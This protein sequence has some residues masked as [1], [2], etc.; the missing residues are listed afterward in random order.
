LG[1][2][3]TRQQFNVSLPLDLVRR[4]KH[5]A[6][7]VQ[8]SLSDLVAHALHAELAHRE[9]SVTRPS[10]QDPPVKLQ[11]MVHVE[12]MAAAVSFYETLGATVIHGSRDGDWALLSLGESQLALLA[13]PPNP[14]Q[15]EGTVE[16]NF[17]ATQPLDQLEDRLRAAGVTI[18][19][20]TTD[21][22]FGRQLQLASPDGL[23][24]KINESD[25]ELYT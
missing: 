16:L 21:E 7:D 20:S 15:N 12:D 4:V 5:H 22:G 23:L 18:A 17:E 6:I 24:V 10:D 3:S 19:R 8:L 11:P 14:E 9:A 13:H 2:P 25:P 1:V